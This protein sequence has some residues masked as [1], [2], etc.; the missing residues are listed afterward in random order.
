MTKT[1]WPTCPAGKYG[2]AVAPWSANEIY[3]V[4][5][6]WVMEEDEVLTLGRHG[7]TQERAGRCVAQ[8]RGDKEEALADV[9]RDAILAGGDIPDEDEVAAIVASAVEIDDGEGED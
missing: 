7:W 8:F 5:A 6:N 2:L 9:I 4:C 3:A 1:A